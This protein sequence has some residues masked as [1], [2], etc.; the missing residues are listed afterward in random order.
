MRRG[1]NWLC[2]L[3]LLALP[4]C[5]DDGRIVAQEPTVDE[6]EEIQRGWALF[7]ARDFTSAADRF[8][9]VIETSPDAAPGYVGLGWCEIETDSLPNAYK[10]LDRAVTLSDDPDGFAGLAAAASALGRDSTAVEASLQITDENYL[11]TGDPSFSYTDLVFI[12]AL[13][14]FHLLRYE[15]CLEALQIL[16]PFLEID[17]GAFDFRE[18]LFKELQE[19]RGDV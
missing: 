15:D 2:L 1:P 17:L 19:L 4:A 7:R 18:Q 5:S 3:V 11:F 16:N 12:R 9:L 10:T 14:L 13:G 6:N 8:R